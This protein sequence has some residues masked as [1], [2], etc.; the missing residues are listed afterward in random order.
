MLPQKTFALWVNIEFF[1]VLE[2]NI[3]WK[4]IWEKKNPNNQPKAFKLR[5]WLQGA[6]LTDLP[7]AYV[8]LCV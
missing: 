1:K 2:A 5:D 7:L 3:L 8:S 4:L 6:C